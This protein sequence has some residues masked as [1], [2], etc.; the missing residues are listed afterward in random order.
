M[1]TDN[2]INLVA[3][4]LV[5]GGTLF[6]GIMAWKSI[7]QT[8]NIQKSEKRQRLLNEIIEWAVDILTFSPM[9]KQTIFE[10]K[11]KKE[12]PKVEDVIMLWKVS[13]QEHLLPIISKGAYINRISKTFGKAMW[14]ATN[15]VSFYLGNTIEYINKLEGTYSSLEALKKPNEELHNAAV[16]IIEEA[17]K[18]KTRDIGKKEENMSKEGEATGRN[19]PSMKDIEEHLK[20]QDKQIERGK[21]G[22]Y[23]AIGFTIMLVSVSLWIAGGNLSLS[24]LFS[25]KGHGVVFVIGGLILL[26]TWFK[27]RKIKD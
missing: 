18:I 9:P 7:R 23:G 6:L 15:K 17:T 27:Q 16:Q 5:G 24:A 1:T 21:W 26:F 8:R 13:L 25:F 14:S 3:A 20:R 12:E 2:W 22:D 4:I 19:E 10:L 11:L